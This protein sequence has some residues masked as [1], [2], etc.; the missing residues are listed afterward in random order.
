MVDR[1]SA[2][3][4]RAASVCYVRERV[5]QESAGW[6]LRLPG[7][8]RGLVGSHAG[9]VFAPPE[10]GPVMPLGDDLGPSRR[11]AASQWQQDQTSAAVSAW[12]LGGDQATVAAASGPG[13]LLRRCPRRCASPQLGVAW[14]IGSL[15]RVGK[16]ARRPPCRLAAPGSRRPGRCFPSRANHGHAALACQR[17]RAVDGVVV[18]KRPVGWIVICR[19]CVRETSRARQGGARAGELVPFEM[20]TRVRL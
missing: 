2:R 7:D 10:R 5:S 11:A 13:T 6:H 19:R 16:A 1:Q 18:L 8:R 3:G 17:T 9:K 15:R 4:T 20:Q 14:S 12:L